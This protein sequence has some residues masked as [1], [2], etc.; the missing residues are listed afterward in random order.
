MKRVNT[1]NAALI[2]A[3]LLVALL[4]A[5]SGCQNQEGPA[6]QAGKSI[7]NAAKLP[8]EHVENAGEAIQH[9]VKGDKR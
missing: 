5:L 4:M 9:A 6:E 2:T 8:S 7:D 1:V 3:V